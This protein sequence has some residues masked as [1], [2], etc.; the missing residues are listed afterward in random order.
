MPVVNEYVPQ[1]SKLMFQTGE[2]QQAAAACIDF[3]GWNHN[4]QALTPIQLSSL[5]TML[6]NTRLTWAMGSF[7]AA[8][9][10]GVLD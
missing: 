4:K 1:P 7:A 10:V 2:G 9:K 5:L 6:A 8:A 3:G